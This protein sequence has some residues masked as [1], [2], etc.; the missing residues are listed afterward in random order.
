MVPVAARMD[1]SNFL[2]TKVPFEMSENCG[3][4]DFQAKNKKKHLNRGGFIGI[5][6]YNLLYLPEDIASN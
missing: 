4:I 6:T 1:G 5:H 2:F 3:N